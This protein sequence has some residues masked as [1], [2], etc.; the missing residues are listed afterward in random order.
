M[1]QQLSQLLSQDHAEIRLSAFQVVDQLFARSH[2]FRTRLISNFQE[3][4]ELTVETNYD[5][6]LPPPTDVAQKLK[7]AAIKSIDFQDVHARTSAERKR[8]EERQKRLDNIYKEKAQKAEKEMKDPLDFTMHEAETPG[9]RT[10]SSA[11][12][13]SQQGAF[14]DHDPQPCCSKDLPAISPGPKND[15]SPD[16]GGE[17]EK[18]QGPEDPLKKPASSSLGVMGDEDPAMFLRSHGL[19]SYKYTLNLEVPS[20]VKLSENED[21]AAIINNLS[22]SFKL[23]MNKYLPLA[24]SWIQLFTRAGIS[25]DHLREAI[26][27]KNRLETALE[28]TKKMNIDFKEKKNW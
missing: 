14:M 20:D 13:A 16:S 4:L 9:W 5:Q 27:L 24:Q 18:D 17:T 22:D 2:L 23:V 1:D 26:D 12:V 7:K 25:D 8:D 6:P 10:G 21:N 19:G 11:Q 28:K 3:F 15:P